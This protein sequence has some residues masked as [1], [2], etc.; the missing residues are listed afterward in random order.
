MSAA[1]RGNGELYRDA[2]HHGNDDRN[3]C[4]AIGAIPN[5][6]IAARAFIA[7]TVYRIRTDPSEDERQRIECRESRKK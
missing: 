5:S 2:E 7:K 6:A 4:N 3:S 1:Q